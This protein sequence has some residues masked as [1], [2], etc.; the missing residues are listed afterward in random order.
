MGEGRKEW[1]GVGMGSCLSASGGASASASASA[2]SPRYS[3]LSATATGYDSD[4]EMRLHRIPR[5][6]FLNGSSQV[7]SLCSKQ[8]RKG[9]NQDT[10]LLWEVLALN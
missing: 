8:G 1:G 4:L 2:P 10:M 7:A 3:Q 5:R 6:L 9:I